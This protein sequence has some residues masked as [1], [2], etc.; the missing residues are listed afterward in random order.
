[1]DRDTVSP[2]EHGQVMADIARLKLDAK[3]LYQRVD[4]LERKA[5][6]ND[7]DHESFKVSASSILSI[8]ETLRKIEKA[9][10]VIDKK[11]AADSGMSFFGQLMR[12]PQHLMWVILGIVAITMVLMGYSYAEIVQIIDRMK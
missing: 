2:V 4:D 11:Q 1:M 7:V 5:W 6:Q 8:Q 3:D 12:N 10:I 9:T